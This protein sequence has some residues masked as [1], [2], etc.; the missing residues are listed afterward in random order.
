MSRHRLFNWTALNKTGELQ[1]GMLLA[2]ER[3]S[4]YEHIIQHGL[5]P[6]GVKGGKAVICTLLAR[7]TVGG[8]DPPISD[9]IASGFTVG[10]QFTIIGKR[11]R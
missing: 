6:L 4:V 5:Q 1:T 9:F 11:G 2:T 8:N 3:N 10:Q 7:G